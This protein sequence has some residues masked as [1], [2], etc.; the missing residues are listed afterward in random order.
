MVN[1]LYRERSS[2]IK[3]ARLSDYLAEHFPHEKL[4][5]LKNLLNGKWFFL[6]RS[7]LMY[8]RFIR[9]SFKRQKNVISS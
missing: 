3:F 2:G 6:F 4:H 8:H 1:P 5:K 9:N 7:I